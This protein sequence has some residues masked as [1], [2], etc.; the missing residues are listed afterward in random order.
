M[1]Y[2]TAFVCQLKHKKNKPWQ[3]RLKFKDSN[4]KWR[5]ISKILPE[6][7]GK[8]EAQRMANEW[9]AEMNAIADNMPSMN[10]E[11]TLSE[12]YEEYIL[13]QLNSGEIEKSTYANKLHYFKKYINPYLGNYMFATLDKPSINNWITTLYNLGLSQNT[14]HTSYSQLKAIYNYYVKSEQLIRNPFTGI[15]TP[16]PG[17]PRVSHLTDEQMESVLSAVYLDYK[18]EDPMFIGILLAYYAGLRR[19]EIVGLRWMD[20]DIEKRLISV[21]SAIGLGP[22]GAYTKNPKNDSSIRTFPVCPQLIRALSQRKKAINP[23]GNWFVCGDKTHF[24][25][26]STF[27]KQF[28]IFINRNSLVDA[29]GKKLIPHALRHNFASLGIQS[30]MDIASLSLMMGHASKA[31]TLDTYGD[32]NADALSLASQKLSERFK[33]NSLIEQELDNE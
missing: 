4:N 15:K 8:R 29:Y 28:S 20:I 21:R 9:L 3:A 2:T 13:Y 16:K 6:A 19:G 23:E 30:S 26:P 24:M 7:S 14:I 11:K 10:S 17:S 12:T 27:S 32:S 5:E 22:S 33:Q 18:P 25:S 1:R 31:M